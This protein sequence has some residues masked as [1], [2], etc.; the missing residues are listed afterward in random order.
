MSI[1]LTFPTNQSLDVVTQ[2]YVI[3][4]SKFEGDG[5]M[6]YVD[7]NSFTVKWDER[8][9]ERGMTKPHAMDSDP[10]IDKRPGS[11]TKSYEG[12]PFKESDVL[13]ESDLLTART[14]GTLGNTLNI[15]TEVARIMKARMDKTMIRVEWA[16]WQALRGALHINENGVKVDEEFPIQTYDASNWS[17]HENATP[18]ADLETA[19]LKFY[20]TGASAAGAKC[21]VNRKSLNNLLQNK[22]EDDIWGFRNQN[23]LALTFS[24]DE[25]NKIFAARGLP[26]I[27]VYDEGYIADNGD[28]ITFVE[29]DEAIIVGK[30]PAGQVVGNFARTI[31]LHR[32]VNGAPAPGF[33]E[34]INVNGGP[35]TGATSVDL[36]LLGTDPNPS[37]KMT[38]GVYG[39]PLLWYPRS[40]IRMD[41]G[42]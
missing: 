10:T 38:G 29:D 42:A 40:V 32:V 5:V 27:A 36:A 35:N 2:E 21:Y 23:F 39:G 22:N 7:F 37:I 1:V 19:A 16:R 18:L 41:V 20:G 12:I 8:D 15:S 25:L 26:S 31:S 24:L 14:L 33:F 30:R 13:K 28:F 17:D 11:K 9:A 3:D 4:R 34:I 6:P